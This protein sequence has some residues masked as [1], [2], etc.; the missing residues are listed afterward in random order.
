MKTYRVLGFILAFVIPPACIARAAEKSASYVNQ[1]MR[2]KEQHALIVFENLVRSF[3]RPKK[4][5]SFSLAPLGQETPGIAVT[6]L[7]KGGAT[8]KLDEK[9]YDAIYGPG[10]AG[11]DGL[12]AV[13][14][15]ELA[16]Y[17]L[18]HNW[19]GDFLHRQ[20]TLLT[21]AFWSL[22]KNQQVSDDR[23]Q[24]RVR[25]ETQA[26]VEGGMASY[27]AGYHSLAAM[28]PTLELL[29]HVYGLNEKVPGYPPLSERV[30][31]AEQSAKEVQELI[32][33][34]EIGNHFLLIDK[35]EEAASCF[36]FM[37]RDLNYPTPELYNNAGVARATEAI[38]LI[39]EIDPDSLRFIYPIELDAETKLA[40]GSRGG[41]TERGF[42]LTGE[43]LEHTEQRASLLLAEAKS[44]FKQAIDR[45][46]QYSVAYLNLA[47]VLQII[48]DSTMAS[49]QAQ[50]ALVYATRG[51][52]L[53]TA[54]NAHIVMGIITGGKPEY[55]GTEFE[56]AK[57]GNVTLASFNI[58]RLA[59]PSATSMAS[60]HCPEIE[61][62]DPE[63]IAD[64]S[65]S[66]AWRTNAVTSSIDIPENHLAGSDSVTSKFRV[67]ECS[68]NGWHAYEM[69]SD[70]N[71]T[72]YSFLL[73]SEGYT[74]TASNNVKI[75]SDTT[76]LRQ[77]YGCPACVRPARQG[78]YWVY[79]QSKIIFAINGNGKVTGW[80]LYRYE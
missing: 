52:E 16:H 72:R 4:Q 74:D 3:Q 34:F 5:P 42:G 21:N 10:G 62:I 48:G 17:Y 80:T 68:G 13:L 20:D 25:E 75:G 63:R 53:V 22:M 23:L 24:G 46:P 56:A 58:A 41:I 78:E 59:D 77:R 11:D 54:A 29:Y 45:D 28:G 15:H 12:A 33:V 18:D 66:S 30:S 64:F 2:E 6:Y 19:A 47:C 60:G 1:T 65:V 32:K 67:K 76:E 57:N 27:F 9:A 38:N 37:T 44:D 8:I 49:I 14:G 36:D 50:Q 61:S 71:Q 55:A 79:E 35:F 40:N 31:F 70:D 43:K 26:D 7:N 73:T 69:E 39:N 51:N